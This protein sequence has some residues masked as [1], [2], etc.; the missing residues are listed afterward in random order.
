MKLFKTSSSTSTGLQFRN[1]GIWKFTGELAET[2][3]HWHELWITLAFLV[4]IIFE[5]VSGMRKLSIS[6]R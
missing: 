5:S 4:Q 3:V 6:F 1:Q 2:R